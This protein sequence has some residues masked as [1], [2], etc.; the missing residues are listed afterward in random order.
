MNVQRFEELR[1]WQAGRELV[2]AIYDIT[3]GEQFKKDFSLSDQIRRAS[4]SVV[5]DIAEGFARHADR[6][7]IQFLFIA[8]ASISEIKSHLYIALD[9]KYIDETKFH[10]IYGFAPDT[11]KNISA[12]IKYLQSSITHFGGQKPRSHA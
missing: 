3:R 6:E 5:A 9:Q 10:Q 4:I 8:V 7:F 11:A 12:L 2:R 1:C